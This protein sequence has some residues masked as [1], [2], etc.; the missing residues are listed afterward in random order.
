MKNILLILMAL[1]ISGHVMAQQLTV[2]GTVTDGVDNLPMIGANVLVKGTLNGTVTDLD[3]QYSLGVSAG[4]VLVFSSIGYKTQEIKLAPGQ[5]LLNLVMEEDSELLDEVVVVGYG[6]MRKS[7]LTGSVGKLDVDELKKVSTVDAA[8]AIQGR[9]AGVNVISN[10]GSPGSGTTIRIRGVGTIN[11]SD[12]LYVVDG[13]PCSDISHVAPTDIESLEVLKDASATAIYGSRGANGV[14]LVKT[15]SGSKGSKM[16]VQ[17]NAY[18]GISQMA[19]TLEMADATQFANARK[20][21][22][23]MDDM[24]QYVLDSQQNGNYLKGTNWQ[25]EI[26]RIALSQRY[27]VG[28]QGA[29]DNYSYSHGVTYSHEK[30]IVKGSEL[31]K[32]MLHTNNT[33]SLTKKVKLGT[34]INYVWYEK[35]GTDGTDFYRSVL[36]GALRSDPVSAAWDSYTDFYGQVYY[37]PAQTNPALSIWQNE[38]TNTA[39]HRFIANFFLQID[40]LFVKGLSFR[41]QY[42]RTLIFNDYKQFSPAYFITA[43]Q[44][45]DTQ[46]LEHKRNNGDTWANTN[47]FSYN[48]SVGKL[49]INATLGME[50]QSNTWTDLWAIGYDVPE[51]TDLQ[52]LGSSKSGDKFQ[53]GG[54]KSQNRLASG[55]FRSNLSWDNKYLFTGTVRYDGTSRFTQDQRWGWFPSFSA[56]WNVANEGFMESIRETLPILKF[57]AGWGLVGNQ[58]SAGDFDYVSSV[59]GGYKY[60]YNKRIV[61]GSVQEQL[62]NKELTWESAEQFNVGI[63]YGFFDNKLNGSIDYFVRK[64]KDMILSRPIPMYAG[65]KRPNVNAGT[66]ENRGV[67][68]A[69]NYKDNIGDFYYGIG[70]NMTWI[71]NK[72]TSLAGGDP[73]RDGSVGRLGNTTMTEEGREIAYFYGHKT[74][75]IFKTQSDIDAYMTSNGT[76][77]AGPGGARPQLGDVIFVDR[78]DDG[79]ISDEDMTY[80]GS[81]TPDLTGGLNIN[82]GYKNVDFTMFM[83]YSLGNEIVNSMYQSL[84]STDMFETNISRDMALNHWSPENPNS[85]LPRLAATDSNKN[86]TT[87]SD[88]MVEDGSFLRIKQIQVGYTLPKAWT[89]KAGIKNVRAYV[90]VD[91]LYTFTNYSG[92]DPEVFGLYG[93]PLYYGVDMINYPQPRTYSFGLNVTF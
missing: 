86:S 56:G 40:D 21:M 83:N 32:F 67:E 66:M 12:P 1:T 87:F 26:T 90:S 22:G 84:Y 47:Y 58:D 52:Y 61:E 3:G 78:N 46:T 27:N 35:P 81:A 85:N 44:K 41:S 59:N 74:N 23:T 36:P 82:L 37:S 17:A 4:D 63:D 48:G 72:V 76:P 15:K 73:I 11:N 8:Q 28:V 39:E 50:I 38:H 93:N 70:F 33:Y 5:T 7:D 89:M 69:I 25:D 24:L 45:N 19:K 42:G 6:V 51:D 43:S 18:M 30:G 75:G 60:V 14:I 20:A 91:N 49:N 29:G 68:F 34:N 65:K 54:G 64:T 16:E 9:M 10:S 71:K 62:A 55:F 80:L 53:L 92:L 79:K 88:L 77:I 13:F 57:R 2:S 31:K